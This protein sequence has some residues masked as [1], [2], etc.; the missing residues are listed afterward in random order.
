MTYDLLIFG[1]FPYLCIIIAIVGSIW[2][3][4]SDRFSYSSLSSQFLENRQLF[5]GSVAWH[6]GILAVL[7]VHL[8]GFLFPKTILLWNT[9]PMRLY[10][11]E[12]TGFTLALFALVGLVMLIIR[13]F[14]SA[15]IRTVTSKMDAVLLTV[16]LVQVA[17][18][19]FTAMFY[20]WG[21]SWYAAYA[22]P[23]LWSILLFKPDVTLVQN[24]PWVM[25]VHILNAFVMILLIPFTRLVHFL[26]VPFEYMWRPH[27]VVI[28]NRRG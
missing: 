15:R 17:T 12:T 22:V 7:T 8:V 25:H 5:W 13:R 21:S 14:S 10:I 27:Q 16:L 24:L 11:M 6:Y 18:G 2:R 28:W 26:A 19:V 9:E 4:S 3:Y 23:Y 20:R 1:F